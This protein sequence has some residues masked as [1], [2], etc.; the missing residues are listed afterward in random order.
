[1]GESWRLLLPLKISLFQT[2]NK[3]ELIQ[4]LMSF[5]SRANALPAK[6]SEKGYGEENGF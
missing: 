4:N 3:L 6:R 1:M 5:V 2:A